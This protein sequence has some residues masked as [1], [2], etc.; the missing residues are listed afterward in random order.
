MENPFYEH[1]GVLES[2]GSHGENTE[3]K[4]NKIAQRGMNNYTHPSRIHKNEKP[5]DT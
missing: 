3:P 4:T 2:P 5:C 1:Q